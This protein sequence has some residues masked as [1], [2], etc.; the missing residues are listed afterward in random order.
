MLTYPRHSYVQAIAAS[1]AP[2]HVHLGEAVESVTPITG[3]IQLRKS[4]GSE[5]KF[6][7]VILA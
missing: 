2:E 5:E 4:D 3:G 7:H 6:D 1:V